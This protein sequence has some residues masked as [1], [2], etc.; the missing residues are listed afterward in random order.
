M[1]SISKFIFVLP[2][3]ITAFN[4]T[5]EKLINTNAVET[6]RNTGMAD[7]IKSSPCPYIDKNKLGKIFKK[8]QTN[9]ANPT[10]K[11]MIL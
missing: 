7:C 3:P 1:V 5:T 11:C 10:D 2:V 9:T 4:Q 6:T 8:M